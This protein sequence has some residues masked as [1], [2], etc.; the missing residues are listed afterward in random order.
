MR[1]Q[2]VHIHNLN[3]KNAPKKSILIF[4]FFIC[5]HKLCTYDH[6]QNHINEQK[7]ISKIFPKFLFDP[8]P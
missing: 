4:E 1:P 7:K 2:V 8:Q 3:P 5:D 6:K